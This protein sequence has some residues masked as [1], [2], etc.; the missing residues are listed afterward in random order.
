MT[1]CYFSQKKARSPNASLCVCVMCRR[2]NIGNWS[3]KFVLCL[4]SC[5]M[6]LS[7]FAY[8]KFAMALDI[9]N[10]SVSK[11]HRTQKNTNNYLPKNVYMQNRTSKNK[12]AEKKISYSHMICVTVLRVFL[13]T[14]ICDVYIHAVFFV[15]IFNNFFAKSR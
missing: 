7:S 6:S 14:F 1:C 9:E 4:G 12:K 3:S 11:R 10:D 15:A 13:H 8:M 2:A 5:H